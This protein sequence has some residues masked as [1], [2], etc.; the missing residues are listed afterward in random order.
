MPHATEK[1]DTAYTLEGHLPAGAPVTAGMPLD[2]RRARLIR[3]LF[4]IPQPPPPRPI[5]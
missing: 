4:G 2:P 1:P 3:T 5:S